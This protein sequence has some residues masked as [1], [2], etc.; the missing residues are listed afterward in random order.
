M[1]KFVKLNMLAALGLAI[2]VSSC[3]TSNNVVSGG[4]FTKRKHTKGYHVNLPSKFKGTKANTELE[5]KEV[6]AVQAMEEET[7]YVVEKMADVKEATNQE[8]TATNSSTDAI[9]T[10]K[11]ENEITSKTLAHKIAS[12]EKLAESK[13]TAKKSVAEK[14]F[15][16]KINKMEKKTSSPFPVETVV[17][18]ILAIFIPPLAVYLYEGSATKTFWINLI[19]SF[20]CW[21]P[22]II[23]A[24]IVVL[25]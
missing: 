14:V 6:M 15:K 19:L 16:N 4:I 1:T 9:E 7:V 20:F 18:V 10:V 24:L 25:R 11:E 5:D 17:L 3:G 8:E 2:V 21:I 13:S 22:G 12:I 23:H